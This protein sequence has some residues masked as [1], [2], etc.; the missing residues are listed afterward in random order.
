[1]FGRATITLGIGPHSSCYYTASP[2]L[3]VDGVCRYWPSSVVCRWVCR[4][5]MG[6]SVTLVSL[7]KTAEPIEMP[8]GLRTWVGPGNH[9]LEWGPDPP[10]G[11]GN[12][13]GGNGLPTVKYRDFLSWVLQKRVDRIKHKFNHIRKVAPMCTISFVFARWRQCAHIEGHIVATWRIRLNLPSAAAMRSYVKL[14]W[15][16]VNIYYKAAWQY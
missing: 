15:P 7:A 8:F 2:V 4:S 3:Y 6:L 11:R 16:L 13:E 14:L 9:V 5:V 12:F 10:M 1:M